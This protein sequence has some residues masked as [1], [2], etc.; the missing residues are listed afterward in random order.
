MSQRDETILKK[1]LRFIMSQ[2]DT[3]LAER[4]VELLTRLVQGQVLEPEKLIHEFE[5]T[6]KTIDRDLKERLGSVTRSERQQG[7]V[8]YVLDNVALS[9]LSTEDLK[10]FAML[11]GIQSLYPN[12]NK[13]FLQDYLAQTSQ[14]N[15]LVKGYEFEDW[16]RYKDI[17]HLLNQAIAKSLCVSFHYKNKSYSHVQPYKLVNVRGLWYLAAVDGEKLKSF[18]LSQL[19]FLTIETQKYHPDPTI[20]LQIKADTLWYGDS[21]Q[22]IVLRIDKAVA[23]HFLR[24]PVLPNQRILSKL[25][26][27]CLLVESLVVHDKQIL[28]LVRY[29]LPHIRI[30]NPEGYQE[31]LNQQLRDYLSSSS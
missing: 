18:A 15:L 12:L 20:E 13:E 25:E 22:Q 21:K 16:Q 28:P 9:V 23:E 6:R 14:S 5:V 19:F 7:K 26:D 30:I 31:K 17:F 24:R 4:L 3:K 1:L 29:W 11:S 27:G 2:V 10:R 8:V